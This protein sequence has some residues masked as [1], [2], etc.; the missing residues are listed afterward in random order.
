MLRKG[1]NFES[2]SNET[3][4]V[5]ENGPPDGKRKSRLNYILDETLVPLRPADAESA[6][7]LEESHALFLKTY[8]LLPKEFTNPSK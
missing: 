4:K 5:S 6:R 1:S 3:N 8:H 7:F 2:M